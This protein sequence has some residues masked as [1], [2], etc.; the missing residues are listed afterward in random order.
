MPQGMEVQ[1]LFPALHPR[2]TP[3]FKLT[4]DLKVLH[5]EARK[6]S[7]ANQT[8]NPFATAP[9]ETKKPPQE[10][11]GSMEWNERENNLENIEAQKFI[12]PENFTM[13]PVA[14]VTA[15]ENIIREA[16]QAKPAS[17]PNVIY[18]E[19]QGSMA[20]QGDTG[21]FIGQ[22]QELRI[23]T[24]GPRDINISSQD[25]RDVFAGLFSAG[26]DTL[27]SAANKAASTLTDVGTTT[28]EVIKDTVI[29]D[30]LGFGIKKEIPKTQEEIEKANEDVAQRVHEQKFQG[31]LTIPHP[32][33]SVF[34]LD[35]KVVSK[36]QLEEVLGIKITADHIDEK[37]K[38]KA[39]KAAEGEKALEDKA[40]NNQAAVQK[41]NTLAMVTKGKGL[42]QGELDKGA[43]NPSHF[44][45]AT[46]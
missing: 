43:E 18:G 24:T 12:N 33:V 26:T 19:Y 9:K 23:D 31:H 30:T 46:G 3:K 16:T 37:G 2:I 41:A 34:E 29:K 20:F 42:G 7:M 15:A 4:L 36:S 28:A 32:E 35:N 38:L 10:I 22:T 21:T 13:E 44:T 39:G 45:K 8:L 14:A 27:K 40:K 11:G 17:E 25:Q 5:Y 1:F 6:S